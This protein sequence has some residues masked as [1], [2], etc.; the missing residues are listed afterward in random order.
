MDNKEIEMLTIN[1]LVSL[2]KVSTSTVRRLVETGKIRR[3]KIGRLVRF[4][5]S[6]LIEDIERLSS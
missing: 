1:D 2:M 5:Y 4:D 3:R 6:Q